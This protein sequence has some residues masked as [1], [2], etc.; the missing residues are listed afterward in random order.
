MFTSLNNPGRN[1]ERADKAVELY[2]SGMSFAKVA[3]IM[4][5]TRQ[6]IYDMV[7]L[8]SKYKPRRVMPADCQ[9][10]NGIKYTK[11]ANGYFL[12][13]KGNRTL[14]HRDVWEFYN[15]PIP[16]GFDIHHKD[17]NRANNKIENLELIAKDE[18]ARKYATGH[19]QFSKKVIL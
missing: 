3:K 16:E 14:M 5:G 6:S 4:G 11:R 8:R 10:F 17:H 12:S 18:H 9:Y 7:R 13:T 1:D 19:N 15:S 2:N